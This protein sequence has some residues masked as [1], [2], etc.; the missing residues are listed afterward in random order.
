MEWGILTQQYSQEKKFKKNT[1]DV[2]RPIPAHVLQDLRF[3]IRIP[4]GIQIVITGSPNGTAREATR[5]FVTT[6]IDWDATSDLGDP[7]QILSIVDL[8]HNIESDEALIDSANSRPKIPQAEQVSQRRLRENMPFCCDTVGFWAIDSPSLKF[9]SECY[10]ARSCEMPAKF[11]RRLEGKS[12]Q[13]WRGTSQ[14]FPPLESGF[15]RYKECYFILNNIRKF[16][17][18]I[19]M[20]TLIA[21]AIGAAIG[22]PEACF[23]IVGYKPTPYEQRYSKTFVNCDRTRFLRVGVLESLAQG[24]AITKDFLAGKYASDPK[25]FARDA[26][27]LS[28]KLLLKVSPSLSGETYKKSMSA[29]LKI[30]SAMQIPTG[31]GIYDPPKRTAEDRRLKARSAFHINTEFSSLTAGAVIKR[32]ILFVEDIDV[33]AA[34]AAKRIEKIKRQLDSLESIS[35]GPTKLLRKFPKAW[36]EILSHIPLAHK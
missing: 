16:V 5:K 11:S 36:H 23:P 17:G 22:R 21:I 12:P 19:S 9:L 7:Q 25:E 35:T 18:A 30:I 6:A 3:D 1:L 13:G 31:K 34:K 24:D 28:R 29:V 33:R 2:S 26:L 8:F 15:L 20:P 32:E 27:K 14:F 4:Q 10:S